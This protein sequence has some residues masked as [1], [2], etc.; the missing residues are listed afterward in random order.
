MA[1]PEG[2]CKADGIADARPST[3]ALARASSGS[4]YLEICVGNFAARASLE[5]VSS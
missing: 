1:D 3:G 4:G 5:P 2:R